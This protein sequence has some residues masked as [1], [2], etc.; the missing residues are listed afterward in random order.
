MLLHGEFVA[1]GRL[2]KGALLL[3][4]LLKVSGE[5]G[6]VTAAIRTLSRT[7]ELQDA[8]F[9]NA[10]RRVTSWPWPFVSCQCRARTQWRR[11][12]NGLR[13]PEGNKRV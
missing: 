2:A 5:G 8:V 1:L 9:G 12:E 3:A 13:E 6:R 7:R 11:D 10:S 4:I